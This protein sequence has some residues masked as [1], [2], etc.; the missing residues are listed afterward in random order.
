MDVSL[1][2]VKLRRRQC[3]HGGDSEI[4]WDRL[5]IPSVVPEDGQGVGQDCDS[6][7]DNRTLLKV[8]A[9]NCDRYLQGNRRRE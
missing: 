3:Y 6:T 5:L 2:E 1:Q 9:Q 8:T 4:L 7:G